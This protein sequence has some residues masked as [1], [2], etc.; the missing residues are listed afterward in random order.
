MFRDSLER[1]LSSPKAQPLPNQWLAS[2]S[3]QWQSG[4]D[5]CA[6][7]IDRSGLAVYYE[8]GGHKCVASEEKPNDFE[9]ITFIAFCAMRNSLWNF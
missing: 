3:K 7:T 5:V 9:G 6:D 8:A 1:M 4:G 2:N